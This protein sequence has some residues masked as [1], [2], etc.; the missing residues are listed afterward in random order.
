MRIFTAGSSLGRAVAIFGT[1]LFTTAPAFA[2]DAYFRVAADQ[3]KVTSGELPKI[4]PNSAPPT[5]YSLGPDQEY[6]APYAVLDGDGEVYPSYTGDRQFFTP[7]TVDALCVRLPGGAAEVKGSLYVLNPDGPG[8]RKVTFVI[9]AEK[10]D[11]QQREAFF[12]AKELYYQRLLDRRLPGGAWFR[13]QVQTA[14]TALAGRAASEFTAATRQDPQRGS[15]NQ[16][17]E[18]F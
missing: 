3:L 6:R 14:S 8:M 11:A 5:Y 13:Y 10:A 17:E 4:D 16:L 1:L 9:P 12:R 18:T 2:E 15:V 7:V